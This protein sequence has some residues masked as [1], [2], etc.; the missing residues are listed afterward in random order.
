MP[1]SNSI[2]NRDQISETWTVFALR[3]PARL[4]NNARKVLRK[5]VLAVPR[6]RVVVSPDDEEQAEQKSML[7]ML[8]YLAEN[9]QQRYRFPPRGNLSADMVG[10]RKEELGQLLKKEHGTGAVGN[11]L[12]DI[13]D[14]DLVTR[15]IVV[16]YKAWGVEHVLR[17]LMPEN[18]YV[19]TSFETVGHI[20]HLNLREEHEPWKFLIGEV[21]L[22]KLGSRIETVV[23]K[24]ASTGGPFR[25]FKMEILAGK[26]SLI[27]KLRENNCTFELDFEKVY[28]NS[29]LEAEHRRI[30]KSLGKDDILADA[31][32]GVGP[33]AVP[34]ARQRACAK[35]FANDLN[36]SSVEYLKRNAELNKVEKERFT[37]SCGC[38]RQFL[39]RLVQEE[40]VPITRVVMNFPSG[41]PEFLDV[42]RGLYADKKELPLPTVHCYC[43]VKDVEEMQSARR[44]VRKALYGDEKLGESDLP[45]MAINVRNVRDVAPRKIQVCVTFQVPRKVAFADDEVDVKQPSKKQKVTT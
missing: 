15:S 34:A 11:F 24:I 28:W 33:F 44:R 39:R 13:G 20:V 25:T 36:P 19:P 35:V 3:V 23:N 21:M 6:V 32:C 8:R 40:S 14:Q 10:K 42:F 29:R 45:D 7:L 43:F 26:P 31:F 5:H 22:E 27:T 2:L 38:A 12:G 17:S 4:C 16:G 9:V 30:V 1:S 37:P 18:V 41:A